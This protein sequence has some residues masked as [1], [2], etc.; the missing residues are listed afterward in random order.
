M[1]EGGIMTFSFSFISGERGDGIIIIGFGNAIPSSLLH[2]IPFQLLT[3]IPVW[4]LLLLL[5][6]TAFSIELNLLSLN[7]WTA[8]SGS[9]TLADTKPIEDDAD[10]SAV[11]WYLYSMRFERFKN[12][13]LL[14]SE[15]II[16]TRRTN[17]YDTTQFIFVRSNAVKLLFLKKLI[18]I[19]QWERAERGGG[20]DVLC[21]EYSRNKKWVSN[22]QKEWIQV[23]KRESKKRNERSLILF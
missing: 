5:Q 2:F 15:C 9:F 6:R 8:F 14:T 7:S 10:I 18:E 1:K 20:R 13:L 23:S 11:D 19:I 16:R 21:N 4:R 22:N 17:T 12:Q 3:S